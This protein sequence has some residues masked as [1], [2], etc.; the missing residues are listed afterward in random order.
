MLAV[1]IFGRIIAPGDDRGLRS[2]ESNSYLIKE[3][4]VQFHIY[5]YNK[6]WIILKKC[7]WSRRSM[8]SFCKWRSYTQ[9]IG[10]LTKSL[11]HQSPVGSKPGSPDSSYTTQRWPTSQPIPHHPPASGFSG[12]EQSNW[13]WLGFIRNT[14]CWSSNSRRASPSRSSSFIWQVGRIT[15][16]HCNWGFVRSA[17]E[18]GRIP[19]HEADW[20]VSES[21]FVLQ[22]TP[23]YIH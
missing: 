22:T 5:F 11:P 16:S 7:G 17:L 12:Q 10:D 20:W 15:A 1:V 8:P 14:P 9:G 6:I 13:P 18:E 2:H 23:G 4:A 19:Y 21:A 3:E